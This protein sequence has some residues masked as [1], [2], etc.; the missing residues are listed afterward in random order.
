MAEHVCPW[1]IGYFLLNPFRKLTENPK[2]M[3]KDYLKPGMK[4][5]E[6]GPGMG[7]FSLGMAEMVTP[8]GKVIAVDLQEKML[9][10]L[11]RRAIKAGVAEQIETRLCTEKSLAVDELTDKID[12]VLAAYVVHEVPDQAGLLKEIYASLKPQG[13]LYLTE[14]KAHVNETAYKATV[15]IARQAGFSII[16][17]EPTASNRTTVFRKG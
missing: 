8:D 15:E 6:I 16:S 2:K 5:L 10:A 12:F 4:V 3:F 13:I 11:K 17:G 9:K 14:P 1:W 7:Y